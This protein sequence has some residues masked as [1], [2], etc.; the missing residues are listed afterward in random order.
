M[1]SCFPSKRMRSRRA[2][3][4]MGFTVGAKISPRGLLDERC[5]RAW[6]VAV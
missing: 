4:G 6:E 5:M 3:E 1:T 2:V